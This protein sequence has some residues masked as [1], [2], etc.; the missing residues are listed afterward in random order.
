MEPTLTAFGGKSRPA[1]GS[2]R[3]F[4][5]RVASPTIPS[6][7]ADG[8]QP[9]AGAHKSR[10]G[11]PANATKPPWLAG[12]RTPGQPSKG[13][14]G[15]AANASLPRRVRIVSVAQ[16]RAHLCPRRAHAHLAGVVDA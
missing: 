2:P 11:A 7:W 10:R 12:A 15:T 1:D 14:P 6:L 9:S 5:W 3:S 4:A 13:G 8:S 16:C